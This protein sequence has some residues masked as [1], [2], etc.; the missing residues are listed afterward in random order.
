ML[1][2]QTITRLDYIVF[3]HEHVDHFYQPFLTKIVAAF[4]NVQIISTPSVIEQIGTTHERTSS[5]GNDEISLQ[6]AEHEEI[7]L[8]P[9]PENITVTIHGK[10]THPGD[11]YQL[12]T[13]SEILAMPMTAPWGSMVQSL[14]RI[15]ALKPKMVIPIHDWH[16]KED[17]LTGFYPRIADFL[18]TQGIAFKPLK[19]GEPLIL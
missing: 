6:P 10:I 2:L 5:T 12:S 13:T 17:A 15:L 11:S 14:K 9:R 4:P 7:L 19:T 18:A 3:T 16:W 1:D 8:F